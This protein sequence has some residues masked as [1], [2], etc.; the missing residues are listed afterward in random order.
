MCTNYNYLE[1]IT[2]DVLGYIV[3]NID[4]TEY[5][6]LEELEAFLN[7]ELWTVDSVTGNASGSYTFNRWTAKEYVVDNMELL[8][9]M[10]DNFGID[11]AEIGEKFRNEEWEYFDVSIRCYLLSRAIAEALE[12]LDYNFRRSNYGNKKV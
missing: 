7:D 1:A 5:A 3:E 6:D 12:Q 2:E 4:L 8:D 11:N 9:E 10:A